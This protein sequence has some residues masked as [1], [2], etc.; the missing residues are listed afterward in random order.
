[1]ICTELSDDYG[2]PG[3]YQLRAWSAAEFVVQFARPAG[4]C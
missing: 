4:R 1:M 2:K 3:Q